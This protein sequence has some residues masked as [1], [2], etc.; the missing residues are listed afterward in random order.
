MVNMSFKSRMHMYSILF[1]FVMISLA[2]SPFYLG[3]PLTNENLATSFL[4]SLVGV[5]FPLVSFR[6]EWNKAMLLIE[7][8]LFALI[9]YT[10]L[11]NPYNYVFLVFGLLLIVISILAYVKKLPPRFLRF[12]Y[13]S[14]KKK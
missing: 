13:Q 9:G 1:L 4:I 7:G 12:F 14:S 3:E 11:I 6:P 10:F 2:I 8:I 5:A